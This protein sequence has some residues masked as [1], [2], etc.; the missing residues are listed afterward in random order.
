M[1]GSSGSATASIVSWRAVRL[2]PASAS[3]PDGM[4]TEPCAFH[5]VRLRLHNSMEGRRR[6]ELRRTSSW[7]IWRPPVSLQMLSSRP[8]RGSTWSVCEGCDDGAE[9]TGMELC[10]SGGAHQAQNYLLVLPPFNQYDKIF[11]LS[12]HI[13][14]YNET[15]SFHQYLERNSVSVKHWCELH[16]PLLQTASNL[17]RWN[18]SD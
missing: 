14:D 3:S 17:P 11:G 18:Y 13:R 4:P 7:H 15:G 12:E 8:R 2:E 5:Y 16:S 10:F 9:S 1:D 6:V